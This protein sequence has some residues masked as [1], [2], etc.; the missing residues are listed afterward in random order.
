MWTDGA[1]SRRLA[2]TNA[3]GDLRN[4]DP[5]AIGMSADAGTVVPFRRRRRVD[6]LATRMRAALA[7]NPHL[8]D[9]ATRLHI[10]DGGGPLVE[11]LAIVT[12]PGL[13]GLL[14][15]AFR[16]DR[17]GR[18]HAVLVQSGWIPPVADT[19][20]TIASFRATVMDRLDYAP[21]HAL[22]RGDV[23]AEAASAM[24]AVE[25]LSGMLARLYPDV[26]MPGDDAVDVAP[27]DLS[28]MYIYRRN[29]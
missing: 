4:G 26:A 23:Y 8:R 2:R 21:L 3:S 22:R 19:A 6:E 13:G 20:T 29:F 16:D 7:R 9:H 28:V 18:S 10:A 12:L 1:P 25:M 27:L 5:R 11:A 15:H 17:D 14:G 24:Q